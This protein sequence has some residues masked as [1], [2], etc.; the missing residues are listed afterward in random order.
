[1]TPQHHDIVYGKQMRQ[2]TDNDGRGASRVT[3]N[4]IRDA[5]QIHDGP[6]ALSRRLP[7][8]SGEP[9]NFL[10]GELLLE[11]GAYTA[12]SCARRAREGK[13]RALRSNGLLRARRNSVQERPD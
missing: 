1:M 12:L 3:S 6:S 2:V 5:G 9:L 10:D 7:Q 4:P 11:Q 13:T 8:P